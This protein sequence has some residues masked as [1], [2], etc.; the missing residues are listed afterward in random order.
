MCIRDS[1]KFAPRTL[2]IDLLTY[3][4]ALGL[5]DGYELPRDE[6]LRYAFVIKPL[7]DVAGEEL[8]P[9]TGRTYR[10]LWRD[11]TG[12]ALVLEPVVLDLMQEPSNPAS[13]PRVT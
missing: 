8:H 11:F 13:R 2:D 1:D 9:A 7:A 6:I 4:D 12:E 10:V 5:V 3:G